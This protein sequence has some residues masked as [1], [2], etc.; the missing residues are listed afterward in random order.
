MNQE[1]IK[2]I[3][4]HRDNMLLVQEAEV[5]DGVAHAK[6][7]VSGEEFFLKGHFPGNP[8]VPGVILCE[9]MAQGAAVLLAS[10]PELK[11]ST[12][13]FTSLDKVRFKSPVK[14]GDALES[15]S[16]ITKRKG[17]FYWCAAKGYVNGKLSVT[18]EFSFALVK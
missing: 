15:E 18:A 5:I 2:Q 10:N 12:P 14:P 3:L 6:Y 8:V 11:G 16:T 4:P 1:E 17:P 9:M 7:H 13:M